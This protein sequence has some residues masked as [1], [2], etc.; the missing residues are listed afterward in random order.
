[1][2][3]PTDALQNLAESLVEQL[4]L[5]LPQ[6][7]RQLHINAHG[8]GMRRPASSNILHGPSVMVKRPHTTDELALLTELALVFYSASW[9]NKIYV[10][11]ASASRLAHLCFFTVSE[12]LKLRQIG[13]ASC[14][15]RV[16][17]PV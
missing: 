4:R 15:E 7:W 1:M 8:F 2:R 3:I 9:P 16:S 11:T 13:R 14:R 17:S 12:C 5:L 10:S 6:K